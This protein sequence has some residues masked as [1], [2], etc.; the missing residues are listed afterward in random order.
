MLD[1]NYEVIFQPWFIYPP[2]D[3]LNLNP[4]NVDWI[5]KLDRNNPTDLNIIYKYNPPDW[6]FP[7]LNP[8][9]EQIFN[10]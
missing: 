10:F 3:G 4:V 8:C 1:Y 2:H 6:E 7:I 9:Q 5:T